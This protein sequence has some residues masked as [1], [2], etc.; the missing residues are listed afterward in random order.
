MMKKLLIFLAFLLAVQ[1]LVAQS[2]P[3]DNEKFK[4]AELAYKAKRYEDAVRGFEQANKALGGRCVECLLKAADASLPLGQRDDVVKFASKA[5]D[6]ASTPEE[7][8]KAHVRRSTLLLEI[9]PNAK[10]QATA[11]A[12]AR[13][14]VELNPM[15]P[16]AHYAL[17]MALLRQS[18]DEAGIAE[19]K[20]VESH[21]P[22]S[23]D[24]KI[25][26][27]IIADPRRARM[28]FAPE[29]TAV[30]S[31]GN[32]VTLADLKGKV[33]LLDFWATWC[34]PCRASVPEIKELRKKYGMDRFVV[35]SISADNKQED[36]S[37]YIAKHDMTWLHSWDKRNRPSVIQTFGVHAFPTYI[38]LDN[39]GIVR[40]RVNGLEQQQTLTYR[41][42]GV[43]DKLL[44]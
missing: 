21:I 20:W 1:I 11:E 43:L 2:S 24:K 16:D 28:V 35:L 37:E 15:S 27:A 10:E 4:A 19:M 13:I 14:A 33:V 8:L 41:L 31:E 12:D 40:E 42:H 17:A 30:T 38:V 9:A 36:W 25:V 26:H 22:E 34:P 5:V 3:T 39:E 32:R 18:K 6:A 23:P 7:K 44:K 29:F